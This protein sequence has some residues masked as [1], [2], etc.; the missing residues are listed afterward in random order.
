MVI[1]VKGYLTFK[2]L[3]GE[4]SIVVSKGERL[5]LWELLVKLSKILGEDFHNQIISHQGNEVSQHV[6]I[7]INGRHYSHLP[8]KINT[9]LEDGDE[10]AMFPP[11]AGGRD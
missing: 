11:I 6:A 7:L 3:I 4:Q 2:Q 8:D 9:Q 5:T 1:T 10:V